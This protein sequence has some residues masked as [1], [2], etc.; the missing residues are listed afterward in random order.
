MDRPLQPSPSRDTVAR[1][2]GVVT[3][4]L[5]DG[6]RRNALR[7]ADWVDLRDTVAAV[8]RAGTAR[9][10]VLVGHGGTFSA[11]SDMTEWAD[12]GPDDVDHTFATMEQCFQVV[13]DCAVP[14]VAAVE[15]VA[16]GAGCQLALS[17]DLV[18]MGES[19][20]IGMPI[21]RLGILASP[22]FAARVASR[23]GS[24]LAADLYLTG[25]LLG[26]AEA[27]AAGLVARVVPD[28]EVVSQATHLAHAITHTSPEAVRAAKRAIHAVT[29]PERLVH[30]A[31]GRAGRSVAF[32]DFRPAV[33]RFLSTRRRPA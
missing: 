12:A 29:Q 21:A 26:A 32:E 9:V 31:G 11:G 2:G 13:E 22:A 7:E 10:M 20:R 17:C 5:G 27:R 8:G 3:L 14:V 19:A 4:E 16:A 33:R 15:G 1:D 28:T 24:A 18:V 23:V 30:D 25:R 6:T